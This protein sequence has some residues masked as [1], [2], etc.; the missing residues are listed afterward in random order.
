MMKMEINIE[1]KIMMMYL[2]LKRTLRMMTIRKTIIVQTL[3]L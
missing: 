3:S 2:K 1:I